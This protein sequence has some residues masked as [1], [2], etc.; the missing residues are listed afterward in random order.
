MYKIE[1]EWS[2]ISGPVSRSRRY[3]Y[4]DTKREGFRQAKNLVSRTDH[5]L[6]EFR[7][8]FLVRK[9]GKILGEWIKVDG[10]ITR[11]K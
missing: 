2:P 3:Q 11:T 6:R 7:I 5:R 1:L 9:S 8:R 10:I 4:P